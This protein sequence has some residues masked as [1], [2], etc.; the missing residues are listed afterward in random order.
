MFSIDT[1]KFLK[2]IN[3]AFM[4]EEICFKA[5]IDEVGRKMTLIEHLPCNHSVITYANIF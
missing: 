3:I 2:H 1:L 5:S 4:I